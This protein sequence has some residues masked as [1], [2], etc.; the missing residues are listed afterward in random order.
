MRYFVSTIT[1]LQLI[2]GLEIPKNEQES[3][4]RDG[5]YQSRRLF[6]LDRERESVDLVQ[7]RREL[8]RF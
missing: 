8:A 4:K 2:E 5:L 3:N 6:L 1:F 7:V